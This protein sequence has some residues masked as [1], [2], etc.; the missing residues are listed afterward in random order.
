MTAISLTSRLSRTLAIG[1]AS[2]ALLGGV[3]GGAALGPQATPAADAAV[4]A[5]VTKSAAVP[6]GWNGT[7]LTT[8]NGRSLVMATQ[9]PN[10][11]SSMTARQVNTS[12]I[13][14]SGQLGPAPVAM[15]C[16]KGLTLN[17]PTVHC[18]VKNSD[19]K[20]VGTAQVAL[21]PALY[22]KATMIARF[23]RGTSPS[24]FTVPSGVPVMGSFVSASSPAKVTAK[25]LAA[26]LQQSAMIAVA[27]DG[28]EP[29]IP[30]PKV[31]CTVLNGGKNARCTITGSKDKVANGTWY[32]TAQYS[33]DGSTFY[34][35]GRTA[36]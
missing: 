31:S 11:P 16:T 12:E 14:V 5:G 24:A 27:G 1:S 2:L 6:S 15:A 28:W 3:L 18:P 25:K 9:L 19:G 35:Y 20:K 22:G 32:G 33:A 17:G 8:S 29:G 4:T 36:K 21:R 34:L 30:T 26:D 13:G 7:A 23:A 10:R